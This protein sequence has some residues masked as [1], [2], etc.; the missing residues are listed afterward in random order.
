MFTRN[1][2]ISMFGSGA[3]RLLPWHTRSACSIYLEFWSQEN[4]TKCSSKVLYHTIFSTS[5]YHTV[6]TPY[7]EL[8]YCGHNV[9]SRYMANRW[10]ILRIVKVSVCSENG[11]RISNI[12]SDNIDELSRCSQNSHR[13]PNMSSN[14]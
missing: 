10:Y 1:Y 13:V 2:L 11:S 7:I 4:Y 6:A 8:L 14:N 3:R 12:P 5:L 9:T